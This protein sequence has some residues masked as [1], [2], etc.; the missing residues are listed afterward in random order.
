MLDR[1][2]GAARSNGHDETIVIKHPA[3]IIKFPLEFIEQREDI[4]LPPVPK[5][6]PVKQSLSEKWVDKALDALSTTKA[7]YIQSGI[8]FGYMLI[9]TVTFAF[10]KQFDPYPFLFLNFAYSLMSGYATVFML[11]NNRRQEA[12]AK[13]RNEELLAT[14]K[15]LLVES[16]EQSQRI[17]KLTG[18]EE[19]RRIIYDG[20]R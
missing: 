9:N 6:E 14:V 18:G 16:K 2:N 7:I 19:K 10:I 3:R 4:K 8:T 1:R 12:V 15:S 11:N 20:T 13:L 5:T 17:A